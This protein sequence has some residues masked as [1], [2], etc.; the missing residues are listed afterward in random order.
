[1]DMEVRTLPAEQRSA[2]EPK[3]RQYRADLS[4]R[5]RAL[6]AAKRGLERASLLGGASG[7]REEHA[8]AAGAGQQLRNATAQLGEAHSQALEAERIGVEVLGDLRQQREVIGH[9]RGSVA[10]IGANVGVAK[11]LLESMARRA[12]ANRRITCVVALF[13]LLAVVVAVYLSLKGGV[14]SGPA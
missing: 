9:A 7:A 3:M 5:R 2:L 11:H 12:E 4:E 13:L 14:G 6:E 8:R 10:E 1:M